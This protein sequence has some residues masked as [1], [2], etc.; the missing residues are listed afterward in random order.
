MP[1][2]AGS[3]LEF[4]LRREV[5]GSG[6]DDA[7]ANIEKLVEDVVA[8]FHVQ[9]TRVFRRDQGFGFPEKINH[10]EKEFF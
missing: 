4:G 5:T 7:A 3:G 8:F 10:V 1:G 9:D 2:Q 6:F